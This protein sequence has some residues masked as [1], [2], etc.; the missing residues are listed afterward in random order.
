MRLP[1]N[2]NFAVP[3]VGF[4][5]GEPFGRGGYQNVICRLTLT[6]RM[7]GVDDFPTETR[8]FCFQTQGIALMFASKVFR[9]YCTPGITKVENKCRQY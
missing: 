1:G 4:S 8:R 5:D 2:D 6:S 3:D 7:I 9:R